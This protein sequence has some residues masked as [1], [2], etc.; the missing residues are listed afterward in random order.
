MTNKISNACNIFGKIFIE[1][2][3]GAEVFKYAF[4]FI[5]IFMYSSLYNVEIKLI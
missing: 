2:L 1:Y 3:I 4:A 5:D